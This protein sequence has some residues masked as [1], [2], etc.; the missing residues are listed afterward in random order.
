MPRWRA[1]LWSFQS[2]SAPFMCEQSHIH[3]RLGKADRDEVLSVVSTVATVSRPRLM[4]RD[5]RLLSCRAHAGPRQRA[6]LSR[7]RSSFVERFLHFGVVRTGTAK[8]SKQRTQR[9]FSR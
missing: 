1:S 2:S 7:Y 9:W 8:I 4:Q 6:G 5:H 3:V